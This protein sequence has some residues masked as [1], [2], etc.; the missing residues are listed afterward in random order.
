[1]VFLFLNF[2]CARSSHASWNH[3][4][5][6]KSLKSGYCLTS[7]IGVKRLGMIVKMKVG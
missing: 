3:W 2:T 1:M 6:S 7:C 5:N 4:G